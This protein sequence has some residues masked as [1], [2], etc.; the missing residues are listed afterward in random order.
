MLSMLTNTCMQQGSEKPGARGVDEGCP[1]CSETICAGQGDVVVLPCG[2]M[3][4]YTCTK[5]ILKGHVRR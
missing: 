3:M 2:H 5:K 1:V 4:C